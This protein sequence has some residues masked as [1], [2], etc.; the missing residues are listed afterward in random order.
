M[1]SDDLL[2]CATLAMEP[3][4]KGVARVLHNSHTIHCCF[5]ENTVQ[6]LVCMPFMEAKD[7]Y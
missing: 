7:L 4:C 3:T 5:G 6:Q 2:H 1:S